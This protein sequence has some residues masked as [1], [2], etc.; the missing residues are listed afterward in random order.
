MNYIGL[1]LLALLA[2]I[3]FF[4]VGK[5][6][7]ARLAIKE[8]LIFLFILAFT[9]GSIIPPI[10]VDDYLSLSIG[11]F[12]IPAT[13]CLIL[14]FATN[15]K[16]HLFRLSLT[17]ILVATLS[18]GA[19]LLLPQFVNPL[20]AATLLGIIAGLSAFLIG[21]N[22]HTVI[23][24]AIA[25]IVLGDAIANIIGRFAFGYPI[26]LGTIGTFDS[27][28]LAAFLSIAILELVQ[29]L[30]TRQAKK[31]VPIGNISFEFSQDENIKRGKSLEDEIFRQIDKDNEY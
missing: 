21:K 8:W 20:L 2:F 22:H 19:R 3:A 17:V 26:T 16:K 30:K 15:A 7:F 29:F 14:L 25:G 24:G 27:I 9:I 23:L 12:I 28:I 1:S 31:Q 5:R 4:R 10:V 18:I 11:G 13:F 6:F